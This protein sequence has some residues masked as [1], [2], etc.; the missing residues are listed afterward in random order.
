[1]KSTKYTTP[2]W[3]TKAV[4]TSWVPRK[5]S[6]N[7]P[8]KNHGK[9]LIE[10]FTC[11]IRRISHSKEAPFRD[12]FL[13]G[14]SFYSAASAPPFLPGKGDDPSSPGPPAGRPPSIA[15]VSRSDMFFPYYVNTAVPCR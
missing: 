3:R 4:S 14:L 13:S 10:S 8:T 1:M 15:G 9:L 7:G 2:T 11:F 6:I 5:S 12:P